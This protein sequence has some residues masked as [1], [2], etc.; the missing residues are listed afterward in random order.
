MFILIPA[1]EPDKKLVA[2]VQDIK[3]QVDAQ[4]LVVD[5]GS[6]PR[7]GNCFATVADLGATVLTHPTNQGKGAALKTGFAFIRDMAEQDTVVVTADSD[8]Q[9]LVADMV[10]VARRVQDQPSQLVLGTRAFVSKV[11][12]RSRFGNRVTA[13]LFRLVTGLAVTDTQTGLRGFS[14]Q[15]LDWL[16]SL[17][18]DRFEYEF[19][20]LLESKRAGIALVEEPI[21]TVYLNGNKSSHFR[22]IQDSLR[23]YA[24]FVSFMAGSGA[25][26][27]LELGL[28]LVLNKLTQNL[29]LSVILARLV[30]AGFQYTIN[31]KLVFRQ[32]KTG[33]SSLSRYGLVALVILAC[34]ALLLQS[35]VNLGIGLL[36]AKLCT[37]IILFLLSY[38]LQQ[39]LVFG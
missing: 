36:L 7:Y 1:Y 31:A 5:D 13:G 16:L 28:L 34:N 25:S 37:E 30:S 33:L 22:P 3:A 24:P 4:I 29:L 15:H 20:M 19:N 32:E 14:G 11:P 2:L 23:I 21:E 39:D 10:K 38:R 26:A 6:G 9:H 27:L 35:L 12:L 17:P 8:G 18:G